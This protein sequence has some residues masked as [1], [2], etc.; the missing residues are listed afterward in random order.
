MDH[1][2]EPVEQVLKSLDS[3]FD[4][5]EP[6]RAASRIA[7]YGKNKLDE[8]KKTTLLGRFIKQIADPMIIMLIAAAL[9]SAVVNE[10]ADMVII[11]LVVML[12]AVLGVIQEN[13]AERAIEALQRMSASSAKVRRGGKVLMV[14]T[15]DIVPG[16]IVLFEAGDA[17]PADMRLI[18]SASLKAEEAP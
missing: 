8:A 10:I 4:G 3:S 1:H 7:Q 14:K 12:N 9:I 5:L 15:E 2:L 6:D 13:K 18:E 11:V 17:V 16:D